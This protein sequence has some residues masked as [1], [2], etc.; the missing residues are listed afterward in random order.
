MGPTRVAYID[1]CTDSSPRIL[2]FELKVAFAIGTK[3]V[4]V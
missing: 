3:L 1:D 4:L 2:D